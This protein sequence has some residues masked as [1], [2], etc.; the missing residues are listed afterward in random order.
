[1]DPLSRLAF[2]PV[3]TSLGGT[4]FAQFAVGVI[5]VLFITGEYSS[6]SIRT[7]FA[8]TPRRIQV[9]VA[10][11]AVLISVT[12]VVAEV[13]VFVAFLMGQRI[14]EGVV[15][16]ASLNSGAVLRSVILGGVYLTILAT[17]GFGLGLILR[18]QS[19]AISVFT[20]LLLIVPIIVFV[21]PQSWQDSVSRYEPSSLGHAMM[22]ATALPNM[23]GSWTATLVLLGY[24]A[25][26]LVAGASL[27]VRRDA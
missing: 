26:V 5:G 15:P 6:G 12:A 27:L 7:T 17:L 21:L 24:V 16:T 3:S 18:Q 11:L 2:D 20:S 22:S 25:V 9:V 19:A 14:Y 1:M 23:F 10:K 13:V 4:L 8:A